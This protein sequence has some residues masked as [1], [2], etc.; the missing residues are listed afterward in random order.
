MPEYCKA[1]DARLSEIRIS[2]IIFASRLLNKI[3]LATVNSIGFSRI[4][5]ILNAIY[6]GDMTPVGTNM[7]FPNACCRNFDITGLNKLMQMLN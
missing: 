5:N 7:G 3:R 6:A 4:I 2:I 1:K